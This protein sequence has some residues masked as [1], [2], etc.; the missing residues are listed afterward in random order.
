[1]HKRPGFGW[2]KLDRCWAAVFIQGQSLPVR[3]LLRIIMILSPSCL[4]LSFFLSFLL[5]IPVHTATTLPSSERS[6][7]SQHPVIANER[8]GEKTA[9]NQQS[10]N[11]GKQVRKEGLR[12]RG[13]NLKNHPFWSSSVVRKHHRR[14]K[15]HFEIER[16]PLLRELQGPAL[17]YSAKDWKQQQQQRPAL[18]LS[19]TFFYLRHLLLLPPPFPHSISAFKTSTCC[20]WSKLREALAVAASTGAPPFSIPFTRPTNLLFRSL[21]VSSLQFAFCFSLVL[22]TLKVKNFLSRTVCCCCCCC[23][24]CCCARIFRS[25]FWLAPRATSDRILLWPFSH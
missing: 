11:G 25:H 6:R 23:C 14:K 5:A 19:L 12:A 9:N 13:T 7:Q 8:K 4:S 1:M 21:V 15:K 20:G 2:T 3:E 17:L 16:I 18:A 22:L 24:R 10:W